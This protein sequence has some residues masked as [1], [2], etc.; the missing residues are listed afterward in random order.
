M[1]KPY[2][3]KDFIE[4]A[5]KIHKKKYCYDKVEYINAKTKVVITCPS[6]GDFCQTPD[7]HTSRKHG[8]R[9]CSRI[10]ITENLKSNTSEFIKKARKIH[11]N[12]YDYSKVNYKYAIQ[13]VTI[14]CSD[15]G[16]F[17]QRPHDHLQG[18]GCSRCANTNTSKKE[19]LWLDSL[20]VETIE[21][22]KRIYVNDKKYLK[23]D[24]YDPSTKTVYEFFGDF[25]HGNP[26]VFDPEQINP[27]IRKPYRQLYEETMNKVA[28]YKK[29]GYKVVWIWEDDFLQ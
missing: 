9:K 2:T 1:P 18:Q 19:N 10:F 15:H 16:L 22:N 28:L 5:R 6:H 12:K 13:K 29:N 20:N 24:G 17:R 27:V 25:W 21:R 11:L 4:K 8:C 3:A 26:R 14:I 7:I 23:P